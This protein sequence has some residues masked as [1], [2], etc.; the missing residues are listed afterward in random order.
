VETRKEVERS[1]KVGWMHSEQ[2]C[3]ERIEQA[4]WE[5]A[6]PGYATLLMTR[7]VFIASS[8]QRRCT[9]RKPLAIPQPLR[10]LR[11]SAH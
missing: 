5:N 1:V 4:A 8:Y 3:I 2:E 6:L 10:L 9:F 11:S 7:F